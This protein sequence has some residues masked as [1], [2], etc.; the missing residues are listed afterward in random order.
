[1]DI[2]SRT[3][4]GDKVQIINHNSIIISA[5]FV[6]GFTALLLL[7]DGFTPKDG[8]ILIVL[9]IFLFFGWFS[10]RPQPGTSIE[11][12]QFESEIGQGQAVLLEM[13]SPY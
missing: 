10:K 9:A 8:V 13:Q 3:K 12:D 5:L 7:R 11:L 1:M 6:F 2:G 4:L